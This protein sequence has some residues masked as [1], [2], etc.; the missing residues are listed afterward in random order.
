MAAIYI[1]DEA[2]SKAALDEAIAEQEKNPDVEKIIVL[3]KRT[4]YKK[5]NPGIH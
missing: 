4:E 2:V 1:A 3:F 5:E